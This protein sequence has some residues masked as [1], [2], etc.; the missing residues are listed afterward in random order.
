MPNVVRVLGRDHPFGWRRA[1]DCVGILWHTG[2][3]LLVFGLEHPPHRRRTE[4]QA[5]SGEHLGELDLAECWAQGLES[6][7][8]MATKSGNLLT[9]PGIWTN[10][11]GLSSSVRL[12][13]AAIVSG[14]TRN[15]RAVCA[16]DHPRAALSSRMAIRS[17]A[18]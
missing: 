12:S 2:R 10:D 18:G 3:R 7:D 13:Q 9:G 15:A 16:S 4:V 6:P 1:F 11:A 17:V 8:N 14:S 5:R